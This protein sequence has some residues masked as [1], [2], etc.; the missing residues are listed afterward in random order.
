MY[1]LSTLIEARNNCLH[2]MAKLQPKYILLSLIITAF[3]AVQLTVD[4]IHLAV[5]HDHGG[6]HHQ[7]RSE[8]HAYHMA[9]DHADT[10]DFSHN[11]NDAQVVDIDH[12]FNSLQRKCQ[13]NSSKDAILAV[14][15]RPDLSLSERSGFKETLTARHCQLER[16]SFNPR[17]PP[18]TS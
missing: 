5:R 9:G 15:H 2:N 8:T 18:Q 1:A 17:A 4:H 13:D 6:S 16:T 10:I 12:S 11:T 14:Y 7:H 3:L